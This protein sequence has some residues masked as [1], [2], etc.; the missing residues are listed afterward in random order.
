M[1]TVGEMKK[2]LAGLDDEQPLACFF[3]RRSDVES[4]CGKVTDDQWRHI[5]GL[6]DSTDYM[7]Y[8]AND[9]IRHCYERAREMARA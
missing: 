4:M 6:F 2:A 1:F 7:S 8:E 5:V 9:L 3:F